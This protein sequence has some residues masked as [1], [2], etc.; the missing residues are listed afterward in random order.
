M[1]YEDVTLRWHDTPNKE[2]HALVVVGDGSTDFDET[3]DYDERVFFY[4]HD[5]E[6]FDRAREG[7]DEFEFQIV[8]VD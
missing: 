2:F 7:D 4:F 3:F 6:E 5:D 1:R 8:S